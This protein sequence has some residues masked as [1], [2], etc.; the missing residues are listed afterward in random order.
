MAIRMVVGLGNP[1]KKYD[2]TRHNIGRRIVESL[3]GIPLQ[4]VTSSF[5][6]ESGDEVARKA[7]RK[8]IAPEEILVV[9]DE[10]Q[11][12]LTRVKILKSGSHGGHNGLKSVLESLGT[13]AVPRMRIG[14]GPLPQGSDPA[15]FVLEPFSSTEQKMV[16]KL[17][18]KFEDAVTTAVSQGLEAAMNKYNNILLA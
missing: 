2:G 11:I 6:N 10:F 18:P 3:H 4:V 8:N 1:G 16:D 7:S 13:E 14:I 15:D 17:F 5:M 12:P 9:L